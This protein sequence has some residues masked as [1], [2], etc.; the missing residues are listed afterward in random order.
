MSSLDKKEE[1]PV[2]KQVAQLAEAIQ[3]LQQRI[4]NLELRTVPCTPQDV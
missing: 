2:E 3:Q 1:E 4:T